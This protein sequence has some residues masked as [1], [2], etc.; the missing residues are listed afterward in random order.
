M[1]ALISIP[2]DSDYRKHLHIVLLFILAHITGEPN[3]IKS[4]VDFQGI[5]EMDSV[6][7]LSMRLKT[8]NREKDFRISVTEGLLFYTCFVL[9]NKVLVSK[10]DETLTSVLLKMMPEGNSSKDFKVFRDDMI[11]INTHLIEDSEKKFKSHK[12][13]AVLKESLAEIDLD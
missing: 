10:H 6:Y 7:K 3:G 11:Y 8:A 4:P 5:V 2:P 13:L 9:M 12:E 1:S